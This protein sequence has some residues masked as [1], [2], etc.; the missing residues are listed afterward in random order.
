M[1]DVQLKILESNV[2]PQNIRRTLRDCTGDSVKTEVL[3]C[4]FPNKGVEVVFH[5]SYRDPVEAAADL[6]FSNVNAKYEPLYD[7]TGPRCSTGR[8]PDAHNLVL[9]FASAKKIDLAH[10]TNVIIL[11]G[12]YTDE[13][14]S[15]SGNVKS[16]P[17]WGVGHESGSC[18]SV[19]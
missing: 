9:N 6:H 13:S 8:Y 12:L 15:G 3:Q 2:P 18:C 1:S 17:C 11:L 4:P 10:P 5:L 16:C 7:W 19:S 14:Q